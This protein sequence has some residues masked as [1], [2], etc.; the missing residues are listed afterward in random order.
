MAAEATTQRGGHHSNCQ[1]N[2]G[3]A[4]PV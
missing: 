2:L 1:L 3:L 4:N